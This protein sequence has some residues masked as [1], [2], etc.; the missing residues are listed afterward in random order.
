MT[1]EK[2][3]M[4]DDDGVRYTFALACYDA[5]SLEKLVKKA[6]LCNAK[7]KRDIENWDFEK[8]IPA[9]KVRVESVRTSFPS[10]VYDFVSPSS[11]TGYVNG[12]LVHNCNEVLHTV[13]PV[14][15]AMAC[16]NLA[17]MKV[18]KYYDD[19]KNLFRAHDL[20]QH[21][22][23]VFATQDM[24]TDYSEY[25]TPEAT[26]WAKAIRIIGIG[27]SDLGG[28]LMRMGLPYDSEA[29]RYTA[30]AVAALIFASAA[31]TSAMLAKEYGPCPAFE[32]NRAAVLAV[33]FKH[34]YAMVGAFGEVGSLATAHDRQVSK[35]SEYILSNPSS[36]PFSIANSLYS[37]AA[38]MMAEANGIAE[39]YGVRNM[40]LTAFAPNGTTG[41]G[42]DCDSTGIEPL[43][44]IEATKMLSGGGIINITPECVDIV[45]HRI[46]ASANVPEGTTIE[47]LRQELTTLGT[48]FGNRLKI[49]ETAM[50]TNNGGAIS[51]ESHIKMLAHL[52][53]FVSGSCSKTV[54]LPESATVEDI[55]DIYKIAWK[56]GIKN[57][58]VYRDKSK[59]AQV[60]YAKENS[61]ADGDETNG[62]VGN[63][64][65]EQPQAIAI[66]PSTTGPHREKLAEERVSICKKL[67]L[68]GHKLYLQVGL[69]EDGRPGEIFLQGLE[70]SFLSGIMD[71]FAVSVSL[72]LQYGVPFDEIHNQFSKREFPPNGWTTDMEGYVRSFP[73]YVVEYIRKNVESGYFE[74]VAKAAANAKSPTDD[75]VMVVDESS[76][77]VFEAVKSVQSAVFEAVEAVVDKAETKSYNQIVDVCHHCQG[78]MIK[79]G[80]CYTCTRCGESTGGCG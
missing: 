21:V 68:G 38:D 69:Y 64:R 29:G 23:T 66:K 59:V 75:V 55:S 45:L 1:I 35:S 2:I 6:L 42:T 49:F 17:M 13:P 52:Q 70:G 20:A 44:A 54:N 78:M 27:M 33:W 5:K 72:L 19:K 60:L 28:L 9:S 14:S 62:P 61:D 12:V 30:G 7:Q 47:S 65:D 37:Q 39:E 3:D 31:R 80:R 53:P 76:A 50:G 77:V 58:A 32:A 73:A 34:H 10:T 74:R 4:S 18:S 51:P 56:M 48:V 67:L 11:E 36:N 26:E 46:L 57:I 25:P 22:S 71:S 43:Y 8:T 79:T 40:Q 63:I 15:G 24:V 41:F 16:C